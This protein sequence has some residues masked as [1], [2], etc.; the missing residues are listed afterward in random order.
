MSKFCPLELSPLLP[1]RVVL[2]ASQGPA[3]ASFMPDLLEPA[4]GCSQ[5][6]QTLEATLLS[7]LQ[8]ETSPP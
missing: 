7:Y 5:G 8:I 1:K 4:A 6:G 3:Q 2:A